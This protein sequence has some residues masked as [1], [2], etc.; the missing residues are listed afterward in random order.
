MTDFRSLY[1][2]NYIYAFDLKGKDVTVTISEVRAA[3]VKGTDGKEQ[4]KPIL[5]FKESHDKRGYVSCKTSSKA[6]AGLYGND[7]EGW[8]GK[9]ITLFP[10]VTDAF[11]KSNVECIRVRP[12]KP[13]KDRPAGEFAEVAAAPTPEAPEHAETAGREPGEEDLY[14]GR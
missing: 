11:G 7:I 4:R 13:T 6:I 5:F 3:K 10:T 14:G 9:R 2:S 8:I 1:D 12:T